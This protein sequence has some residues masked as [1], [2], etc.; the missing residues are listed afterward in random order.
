M[1]MSDAFPSKYLKATDLNGNR[2]RV[3]IDRVVF[4]DIGQ[5]EDKDRKP[6]LYFKGKEK[7]VVMNKTNATNIAL[8][9]GDEM[10]DWTGVDVELFSAMVDFQGRSVE[11]IRIRPMRPVVKAGAANNQAAGPP[12]GHPAAMDEDVPFAPNFD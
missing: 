3:T 5:G 6:V 7:G 12:A 4:E 2:V 11:A 1:K 10:D 9:Y 8:M